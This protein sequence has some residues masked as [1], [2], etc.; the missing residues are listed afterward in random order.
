[1]TRDIPCTVGILTYNSARTLERCLA[2]LDGFAEILIS[3]GGST[4]ETLEIAARF[5]ARVM[6]QSSPGMPI[7]DF[8]LERNCL[9]AAASFDWFFYIDSDEY[10]SPEL[11]EEIRAAASKNAGPLIYRV[12]WRLT[13]ESRGIAYRAFKRYY[14]HRFFNRLSGARF[15]PDRKMHER[16]T[17]D[18]SRHTAGT[19]TG[20]WYV[21]LDVQLSFSEYKRR[22]D[23]RIRI[24]VA[25]RPNGN[26]VAFLMKI[27]V[28]PARNIVK[29]LIR[30]TVLRV[31]YP[32]SELFPVRYDLYKLYS[33]WV[34]VKEAIRQQVLRIR[35][36][37]KVCLY[38]ASYVM[39]SLMLLVRRHPET[40]VLMYHA[41]NGSGAR[42]A[43]SPE[44]FER[45][46]RYL[47]K[48]GWIVTTDDIVAYA[49]G[50]RA[51]PARA[52]AITFDDGYRDLKEI[53][54]PILKKYRL[55][56][57]VFLPTDM[58]AYA[59]PMKTPRVSWEEVRDIDAE[60]LMTFEAHGR[61][62]RAL[63]PLDPLSLTEETSGARQ[64]IKR[65]LGKEPRYFAYPYG[66][67]STEAEQAVVEAGYEAAFGITEGC[68]RPGD[69]LFRIKRVQVDSTMGMLLFTLR[70]TFATNLHRSLVDCLRRHA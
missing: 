65:E 63:P 61:F 15:D 9:L 28:H 42:L 68:V 36:Q 31:R 45:Q 24:M 46:M 58:S 38:L 53:V 64:D 27:L 30:F 10:L 33:E 32:A 34:Y 26:L 60:N 4:D 35:Q 22:V 5:G 70:L 69:N 16:I 52:V 12:S 49:R 57:T 48:K 13:D 20:Y 51:L 39:R 66:A 23:H 41:V 19:L 18:T 47:A 55:P 37:A 11:K 29:H 17:F 6:Q 67:W 40:V 56:A 50:E 59:D 3:D 43:V 1:M 25:S 2:S 21:P 62:H 8:S 14:Q 44:A 7:V 54:F